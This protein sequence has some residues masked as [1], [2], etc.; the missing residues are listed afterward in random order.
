MQFPF[1]NQSR[2][3]DYI[4]KWKNGLHG[5]DRLGVGSNWR[6]WL[7]CAWL[8]ESEYSKLNLF[9]YRGLNS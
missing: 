3:A 1:K 4:K 7:P 5:R 2:F 9:I 6:F 8:S